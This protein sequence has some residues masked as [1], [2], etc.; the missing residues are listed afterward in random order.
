MPKSLALLFGLLA[1]LIV[2][3]EE[4]SACACCTS[5]GQ[6]QVG[7]R[8]LDSG[9][10]DDISRLRFNAN[11]QLFYGE[12]DPADIKGIVAASD[13]YEMHVAQEDHR[14]VFD[15][16]DKAGRTG[17]LVLALPATV[18]IFEVDPRSE[19][20]R[21]LGPPLYKEWTLTARAGGTGIFAPSVGGRQR[22]SLVLHG[23][24]NSCTSSDH[25]THWTLVVSGPKAKY[26]LFG[27]LIR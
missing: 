16:R 23:S 20:D 14:W 13:R 17:T 15:F 18:A 8:K 9:K 7:I 19:P 26:H 22:L 25:F 5:L 4:A 10:H 3:I 27:E 24:G 11:A 1:G 6:R 21:G 2:T 12:A